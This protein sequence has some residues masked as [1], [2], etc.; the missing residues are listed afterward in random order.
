MVITGG[1]DARKKFYDE[2]AIKEIIVEIEEEKKN[3]LPRSSQPKSA[4]EPKEEPAPTPV[5]PK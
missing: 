1:L 5:E 3:Q 4:Q 2:K